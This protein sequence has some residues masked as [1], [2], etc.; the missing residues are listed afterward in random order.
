MIGV[1]QT[2]GEHGSGC[3]SSFGFVFLAHYVEVGGWVVD[4]FGALLLIV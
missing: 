2:I 4:D 3:Y 1:P